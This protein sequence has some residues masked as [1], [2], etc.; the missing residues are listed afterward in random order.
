MVE[1]LEIS[2]SEE[3]ESNRGLFKGSTH[4]KEESFACVGN[5]TCPHSRAAAHR[6]AVATDRKRGIKKVPYLLAH[7]AH[8]NF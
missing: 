1:C 6:H 7:F 4:W 5:T 8:P 2:K 3:S